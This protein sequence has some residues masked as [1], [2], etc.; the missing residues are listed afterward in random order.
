MFKIKNF[1]TRHIMLTEFYKKTILFIL[2]AITATFQA[3]SY[4]VKGRI[5]SEG[6]PVPDVMVTITGE[7]DNEPGLSYSDS[8]GVFVITDIQS[9]KIIVETDKNGY[10]PL[11]LEVVTGNADTDLGSLLIE[12]N[13]NLE[14]VTVTAKSKINTPD[15]T[16]VYVGKE[17][18][19]R[20]TSPLN[21]LTIL[22]YKAPQIHVRESDRTLTIDGEEPVILVNGIKRPMSFISSLNPNDIEKIE[23]STLPDVRF[24]KC[25]LNITTRRQPDGGWIMADLTGAVTT[26][27]YFL[28]GVAEYTRGK[29]DFMLYYNGG[30]RHGR[31]E[32][33]DSEEHYIGGDK[34]VTLSAEGKPSSTLDKYHNLNFYFTRVPS[35]RSMFSATASLNIHDNYRDVYDHVTDLYQDYDRSNHRGYRMLRPD[36]NLYYYFKASKSAIIEVNAVGSYNDYETNRDLS[37]STGY[38]SRLSTKSHIWHFSAEAIWKQTLPFAWLNTGIVISH[39]NASNDYFIDG[40]RSQQN[41]SSTRL[42]AYTSISGNLL[43]VGY[44][45]SAG[46][47][48]FKVDH[49][50]TTPNLRLSLSRN[51]GSRFNLSYHCHYT[52]GIP[53]V[54]SYNKTVVPVNDLMYHVGGGNLKPQQSLTNQIQLNF[55]INKFYLSL[56]SSAIDIFHP[57]LTDYSYQN[58]PDMPYYGFFLEMPGNGNAFR[59]YGADCNAGVSNLWNF[60]SFSAS[61]GWSHNRLKANESFIV[62]SWYLDLNMGL[63]WKGWQL[64]VSGENLTPSR[65]MQGSNEIIRRWPYTSLALYKKFGNLNLHVS[66]SNILSG[67]GGRYRTET[68]SSVVPHSSEFRM[69]DQ[70]NLIEIG[71]R[72]QFVTGRLLNKKSRSIN[73]SGGGENGIRWDY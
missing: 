61:T 4:S 15:K 33:I 70:G 65:S 12:R 60:L 35:D 34:D 2:L 11:R 53:P 62:N 51:F 45:L 37:Y 43:T 10:T 30:Y 58:D 6:S 71:V 73:L 46:I 19:E 49:S 13:I 17:D 24:G 47:N 69:N 42:N 21:M 56:K 28:A 20:A 9:D 22:A 8:K 29:N 68:L 39:D 67:Y 38:D 26:P 66:W 14:E 59:S 23:F 32:Y 63:Y 16:I 25:Y 40:I 52:P 3:L 72:Y 31:K 1:R 50:A 36:L 27:R 44:Y 64:N 5:L 54:S 7:G 18:K 48:Y 57:L 41:L 55:N